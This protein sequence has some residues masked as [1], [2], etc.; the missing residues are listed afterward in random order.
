MMSSPNAFPDLHRFTK[1]ATRTLV[2]RDLPFS[3]RNEHLLGFLE[4]Q[5][6]YPAELAHVCFDRKQQSLH[7]GYVLFADDESAKGA[8]QQLQ[9]IRM[10]GRDLRFQPFDLMSP[11]QTSISGMIHVFFR[12]QSTHVRVY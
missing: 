11:S 6:K 1:H 2:V 8:L 9:G 7:Y 4:Q 10:W 5:L 3:C 12:A